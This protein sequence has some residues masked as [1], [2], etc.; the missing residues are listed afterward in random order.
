MK[1][2]NSIYGLRRTNQ[3]FCE[4]GN[5]TLL[6]RSSRLEVILIAACMT[7]LMSNTNGA[8]KEQVSLNDAL[9]P[10]LEFLEFLGQFET[11]AGEW[12]D[13]EQLLIEDFAG[14]FTEPVDA[15][16]GY[17]PENK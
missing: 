15:A 11:N 2:W 14:L 17:E 8:E 16:S 7:G 6:P 5:I 9:I 10:D 3:A 1:I 12:I 13:P 4:N